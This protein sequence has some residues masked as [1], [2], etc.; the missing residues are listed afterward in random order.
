MSWKLYTPEQLE[1]QYNPRATVTD[2]ARYFERFVSLSEDTRRE[3]HHDL[4][5]RYGDGPKETLDVFPAADPDAPIH[6]FFHGGYWRSQDKK[7]YAFVARNLVPAGVT[8]VVANYDL[9][10][11]VRVSDIVRQAIDC[12]R[13]VALNGRELGGDPARLTI[14]GHS[15]GGQLVA[16]L[17]GFDWESI[18]M[19]NPIR[20]AV[21]VS[22]VFE[23]EPL[24]HTSINAEVHMDGPEA[25]ANSPLLEPAPDPT[26]IWLLVGG[27]EPSEF[28]RQSDD[29]GAMCREAG[30]TVRIDHIDGANHFSVLSDLYVDRPELM[31]RLRE[32]IN[33]PLKGGL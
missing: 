20:S 9:C 25:R 15:A 19:S 17:V 31:T 13:Y 21:S 28:H 6:L 5:I 27:D 14:S 2:F 24:L 8:V 30:S 32:W 11:E 3:L 22:G 12:T 23:L 16:K 10:P 7:D 33:A 18:G 1:T 26:S 29:Y 4:D